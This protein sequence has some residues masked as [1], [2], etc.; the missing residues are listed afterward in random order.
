MRFWVCGERP[1]ALGLPKDAD[2]CERASALIVESA[3][4]VR[5]SKSVV[6]LRLCQRNKF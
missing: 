6:C 1:A 4:A 3:G 2:W 5:F